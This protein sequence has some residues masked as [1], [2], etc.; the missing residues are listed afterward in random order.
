[1]N[2]KKGMQATCKVCEKLVTYNGQY[3]DHV[4]QLKPTHMAE[5]DQHTF[6]LPI[7]AAQDLSEKYGLDQVILLARTHDNNLVHIVTYGKS[8]T[9]C[10]HAAMDGRKIK[11]MLDAQ[12]TSLKDA[13]EAAKRVR[14]SDVPTQSTPD[15]KL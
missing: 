12:P 3:W 6:K 9:D 13:V 7:Q 1:M 10:G 14:P 4:G 15:D 5:V 11:A 2:L 8:D